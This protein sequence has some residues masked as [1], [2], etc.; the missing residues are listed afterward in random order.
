M[1]QGLLDAHGIADHPARAVGAIHHQH[2]AAPFY[3]LACHGGDAIDN[4]TDIEG[5]EMERLLPGFHA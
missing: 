2:D 5:V 3:R 4:F 1:E